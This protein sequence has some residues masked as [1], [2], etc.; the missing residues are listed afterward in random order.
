VEVRIR[1]HKVPPSWWPKRFG[2]A[3]IVLDTS[4][5]IEGLAAGGSL[6]GELRDAIARNERIVLPAL[7]LYE[8]T[9]GPALWTLNRR[10]FEDVPGLRLV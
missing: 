1:H 6:K 2:V 7:V 9:R 4:V 3:V 5:L 8:W 10:D